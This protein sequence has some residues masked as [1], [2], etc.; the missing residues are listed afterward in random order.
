MKTKKLLFVIAMIVACL[1]VISCSRANVSV[2]IW[3]TATYTENTEIGEGSTTVIAKVVGDEKNIELT[4]HTD[5]EMLGD[6]LLEHNLISGDMGAYG[7]YVKTVNGIFA[8]Y[9][10]T[11]SYWSINKNGEYMTQ[12]VDSAEIED[13]DIFEFVYTE[14]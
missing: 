6:A 2:D 14:N 10:T 11:K 12:G 13:G 8:D 5:K 3:E 1:L 9:N 4:V 7:L